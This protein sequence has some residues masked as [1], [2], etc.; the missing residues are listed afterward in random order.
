MGKPPI[1]ALGAP[2][3]SAARAQAE[4]QSPQRQNGNFFEVGEPEPVDADKQV[5]LSAA[6]LDRLAG[7]R[8]PSLQP[9]TRFLPAL[10]SA[11]K[12]SPVDAHQI[13]ATR[14]SEEGAICPGGK[15]F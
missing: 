5:G 6:L 7:F 10:R 13:C 14:L 11:R 9:A 3:R 1:S 4:G 2:A 12:R 15:H 8:R